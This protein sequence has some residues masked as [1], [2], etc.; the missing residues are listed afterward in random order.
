MKKF[1]L[2]AGQPGLTPLLVVTGL[3]NGWTIFDETGVVV[4]GKTAKFLYGAALPFSL[5]KK[6]NPSEKSQGKYDWYSLEANK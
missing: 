2:I 1:S 3:I 5:I 6:A 4:P